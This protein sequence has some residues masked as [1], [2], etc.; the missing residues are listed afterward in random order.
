MEEE[1]LSFLTM[2]YTFKTSWLDWNS[3]LKR[4]R[5][6]RCWVS[7]VSKMNK[8]RRVLIITINKQEWVY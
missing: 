1:K 3:V 2:E 7:F 6:G 4:P 8:T 5:A